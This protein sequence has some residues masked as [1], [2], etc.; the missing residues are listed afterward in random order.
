MASK[1]HISYVAYAVAFLAIQW[2]SLHLY[3]ALS[4]VYYLRHIHSLSLP[5]DVRIVDTYVEFT[6]EGGSRV[7]AR[8]IVET[9]RDYDDVSK[10]VEASKYGDRLQAIEPSLVKCVAEWPDGDRAL[11]DRV[12]FLEENYPGSNFY[13]INEADYSGFLCWIRE[14]VEVFIYVPKLL[15]V[16][17][18]VVIGWI[19]IGVQ[20]KEE[21]ELW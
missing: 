14:C 12:C 7:L 18:V 17:D 3:I 5:E 11:A 21:T 8:A 20:E 6:D 1:K 16:V 13:V 4:D 15:F 19:I 10:I 9:D 2:I